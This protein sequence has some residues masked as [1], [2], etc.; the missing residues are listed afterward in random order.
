[1]ERKKIINNC[2]SFSAVT[3]INS[4]RVKSALSNVVSL[5]ATSDSGLP[6]WATGL[7]NSL[8]SPDWTS[9]YLR[10]SK[11]G[12]LMI[13]MIKKKPPKKG[14]WGS[15]SVNWSVG[16]SYRIDLPPVKDPKEKEK[17]RKE[18]EEAQSTWPNISQIGAFKSIDRQVLCSSESSIKLFW[19][20]K[21]IKRAGQFMSQKA[22]GGFKSRSWR[23]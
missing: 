22:I 6:P 7:N 2:P 18:S 15:K 16:L 20:T 13:F 21:I 5:K 11:L 23:F 12:F 17:W 4:W 14:P 9:C 8:L 3:N 10:V 19:G 1:M